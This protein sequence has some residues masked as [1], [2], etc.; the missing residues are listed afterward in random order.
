MLIQCSYVY[1]V[2]ISFIY[3]YLPVFVPIYSVECLSVTD[4]LCSIMVY[5]TSD[6]YSEAA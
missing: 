6:T 2:E 1:R 5:P 3:I 4:K